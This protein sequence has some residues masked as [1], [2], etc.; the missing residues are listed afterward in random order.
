MNTKAFYRKVK[1]SV[2]ADGGYQ[3]IYLDPKTG[4]YHGA[5]ESRKDGQAVGY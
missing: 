1:C 5:S 3:A 4:F 2:F